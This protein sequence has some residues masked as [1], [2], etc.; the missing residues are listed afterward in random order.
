ME[1]EM[2]YHEFK[3]QITKTIQN[4]LDPSVTVTVRDIT[5]NNSTHLDGLLILSPACN[6]S[7]TIYLDYYFREY[8]KGIPIEKLCREIIQVYE[9]SIPAHSIDISFFTDYDRVKTRIIFK[10]VNFHQ[11]QKLLSE[12][13]HY[14]F[15]DLAIVF[16]CLLEADAEGS[17]TIL[18]YNHHL[19][20]WNITKDDLYALALRNTPQLLPYDLR[21][22]TD[23]LKEL[24]FQAGAG[25]DFSD[26]ENGS[27]P[28]FSDADEQAACSMYVL[29]NRHK[30]N[31]SGCILYP[32]LLKSFAD[33][34]MSDL[35]ILPSSIHEV[36]LIPADGQ[37]SCRE[38][39]E[40]VR[41]VNVTQLSQEEILSDHVY[42]FSRD[43]CQ[44]TM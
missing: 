1:I 41:E 29:S 17:A 13:P 21:N 37:N 38:L 40:M 31:G 33:R 14:R 35:F 16:N 27:K 39:S 4:E 9:S 20:Y 18:I 26:I 5:K 24:L 28:G 8:E 6:L 7:P 15:L 22:M 12:V 3:Q 2:N 19:K 42:Y 10:L 30:L 43:T 36:L 34:L 11:N 23:I 44:I 32:N 25:P